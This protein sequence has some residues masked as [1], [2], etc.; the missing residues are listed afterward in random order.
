VE[1]VWGGGRGE[2]CFGG[3]SLYSVGDKEGLEIGE[4]ARM[5]PA[6]GPNLW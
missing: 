3:S 5:A 2:N 4:S 1:G 6:S